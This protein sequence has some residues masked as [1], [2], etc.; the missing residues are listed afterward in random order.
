MR[1]QVLH[2]WSAGPSPADRHSQLPLPALP[3]G[4]DPCPFW[5]DESRGQE[6][7]ERRP[8]CLLLS[9]LSTCRPSLGLSLQTA[10]LLEGWE[11]YL[12]CLTSWSPTLAGPGLLLGPGGPARLWSEDSPGPRPS[13]QTAAFNFLTSY[14]PGYY[15]F[16]FYS[17][18]GISH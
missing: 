7:V 13:M 18:S 10:L 9:C 5:R 16:L 2:T 1:Q 14:Y 6:V 17:G 8:H 4:G 12:A 3:K 15:Q 11:L